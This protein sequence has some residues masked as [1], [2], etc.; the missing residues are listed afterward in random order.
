MLSDRGNSEVAPLLAELVQ[1]PAECEWVEFKENNSDPDMIGEYL[2][3]L[4]NSAVLAG[5]SRAY[6]VW[7]VRNGDHAVVGTTFDP[8]SAKVGNEDLQNWLSHLLTPNLHFTFRT[9]ASG[10]GVPVVILEVAAATQ[11]PVAFKHTEYVRVGSY[12]KKLKDHP[13]KERLLWR[14]FETRSFEAGLASSSQSEADVVAQLDYPAYFELLGRPLPEG[15]RGVVEALL[16]D[17]LLVRADDGTYGVTHLGAVLLARDLATFPQLRRKAP[18][19]VHYKGTS[20]VH[21]LREQEGTRG[22]AAGFAG[23][24]AF[25]K[26]LLPENEI[27]GEALRRSAPLYPELAIRELVA[28]ALIHQD[29]TLTGTGPMIELFDDRLEITNPGKPLVEPSRFVD[30][31]PQSRN[32]DLAAMLRRMGVC[33]ERG[34]GWEKVLSEAEIHQ[35]PP[36]LVEATEH[37]TRAIMFAPRPLTRM[38]RSDRIRAVYQHACLKWV[39]RQ[40]MTNTTVR[41]RFGIEDQNKAVASRLLREAVNAGAITPYDADVGPRSLR[42]VP[43]WA[44]SGGS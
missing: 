22:Y 37:H 39:T 1:L 44:A 18:R 12:K 15:R 9:G 6:L 23:L 41:Q 35:L 33:E 36:P 5:R 7:G 26:G 27:I 4:A 34:S 30:L 29:F 42:Y 40:H 43:W 38:D 2:S 16:A 24:I 8:N 28:N 25:L 31:P 21:T 20:R 10:A 3:A 13:E 19:V 32:E 14:A 11:R 17:R